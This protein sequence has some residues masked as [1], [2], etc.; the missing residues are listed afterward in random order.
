[1]AS[2]MILLVILPDM[3]PIRR[4]IALAWI[5]CSISGRAMVSTLVK[6]PCSS[7]AECALFI[8]FP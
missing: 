6:S 2:S 4:P 7:S 5:F 1:M 3:A 8:W